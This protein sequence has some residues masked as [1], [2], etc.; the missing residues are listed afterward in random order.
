MKPRQSPLITDADYAWLVKTLQTLLPA[1]TLTPN[2]TWSDVSN[3]P[4]EQEPVIWLANHIFDSESNNDQYTIVSREDYDRLSPLQKAQVQGVKLIIYPALVV[5]KLLAGHFIS[6]MTEG[7][8]G[9]GLTVLPMYMPVNPVS[10]GVEVAGVVLLGH[11]IYRAVKDGS[12]AM[13]KIKLTL[14]F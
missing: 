3:Y 10:V 4:E 8:V 14:P 9:L 1:N 13:D 6:P 7:I 5:N 2:L 11:A 12:L